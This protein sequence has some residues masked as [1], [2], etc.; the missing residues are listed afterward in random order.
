MRMKKKIIFIAFGLLAV[1]LTSR[2]II[3][4]EESPQIPNP[5]QPGLYHVTKVIDG[6]TL[7]INMDGK[8]ETLRLIGINT[9]ET[10]DPRKP[11]ECFGKAASNKAKELLENQ[12]VKIETDPSQNERDKYDR[13][14]AC[15]YRED[16]LFFNKYMIEEGYAHEYTYNLPYQYQNEFKTAEALAKENKKGLWADGVCATPKNLP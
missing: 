16:G 1:Y 4:P 8:K 7:A 5:P 14:R 3:A 15:V 11:V 2:G 12:N 13:L 10:V 6:D 9:P